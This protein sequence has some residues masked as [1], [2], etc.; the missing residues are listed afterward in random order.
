M[1]KDWNNELIHF[2][3]HHHTYITNLS[4]IEL[5]E[6]NGFNIFGLPF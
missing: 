6:G 2:E 5:F 4:I 1:R 3:A